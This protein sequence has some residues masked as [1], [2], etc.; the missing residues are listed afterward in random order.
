MTA[1]LP[2]DARARLEAHLNAVEQTLVAVGRSREQRRAILD[3]LESQIFDMLAKRSPEPTLADVEATLCQL[4]PPAAY[5]DPSQQASSPAPSSQAPAESPHIS[6]TALAG[7]ACMLLAF[8]FSPI[9]WAHH[10]QPL[11]LVSY[12][13]F[14]ARIAQGTFTSVSVSEDSHDG[15]FILTGIPNTHPFVTSAPEGGVIAET[16]KLPCTARIP[17]SAL[18]SPG[19]SSLHELAKQTNTAL[20]YEPSS[21]RFLA[22]LANILAI[23]LTFPLALAA[24]V[25]GWIAFS[26]IRRSNGQLRGLPLALFDGLCVPILLVVQLTVTL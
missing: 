5:A 16:T 1:D 3:D 17:P 15:S 12:Q 25:L 9:I 24:T 23:C 18:D 26:Q 10:A 6:R 7:F 8:L 13:E 4:D 2:A 20:N 14:R 21:N 22:T 11:E 19:W